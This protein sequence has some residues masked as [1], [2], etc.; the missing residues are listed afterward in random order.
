MFTI[1]MCIRDRD[2]LVGKVAL[3]QRQL[4]DLVCGL[5]VVAAGIGADQRIVVGAPENVPLGG[6]LPAGQVLS[7]IHI[8]GTWGFRDRFWRKRGVP[9]PMSSRS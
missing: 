1:Q 3:G 7:L 4:P 5:G 8:W 9:P 2:N 6:L